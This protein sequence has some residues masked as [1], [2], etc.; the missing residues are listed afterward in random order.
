[1]NHQQS[2]QLIFVGPILKKP[3]NSTILKFYK[4]DSIPQ[5]AV[6]GGIR[7]AIQPIVW[8]GDGDSGKIDSPLTIVH[9]DFQDLTDLNFA[10]Q[11]VHSWEWQTLHLFGFLGK[12]KDH[13]WA[14]LGEVCQELKIRSPSTV[15][16]FYD[17]ESRP[18]IH[19]FSP[20]SHSLKVN[21]LFSML[22]F[23]KSTMILEGA[24]FGLKN[25]TLDAFS[26]RGISNRA[27]G[28][29]QFQCTAPLIIILV[30]EGLEKGNS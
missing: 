18:R 11:H 6:D 20:G 8:L 2:T 14:N 23:E 24:D 4:L 29:I 22:S 13:E 1:M 30:D 5:I 10:I 19:V 27:N 12:R 17:E 21:G 26:G 15:A 7:F 16:I 25:E 9:K 28:I 3:L